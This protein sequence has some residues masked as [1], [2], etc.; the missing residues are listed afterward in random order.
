LD[1]KG[2]VGSW[3]KLHIVELHG[4]FSSPNISRVIKSRRMWW[5]GH[6]AHIGER[7]GVY[8]VLDGKYE[9]KKPLSR[10]RSRWED[11]IQMDLREIRIDGASWILLAQCKI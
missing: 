5:A 11:N 3:R 9:G 1:L 7:K 6:V 4:L 2:E 8:R 10:P